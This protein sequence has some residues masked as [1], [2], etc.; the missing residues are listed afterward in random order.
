MPRGKNNVFDGD[1]VPL[2]LLELCYPNIRCIS[3]GEVNVD[4]KF[5]TFTHSVDIDSSFIER[6]GTGTFVFQVRFCIQSGS[7]RNSCLLED[8]L[9]NDDADESDDSTVLE[10]SVKVYVLSDV[11]ERNTITLEGPRS[12]SPLADLPVSGILRG[13]ADVAVANA[14][15]TLAWRRFDFTGDGGTHLC[16]SKEHVIRG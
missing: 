2:A 16:L 10:S 13:P 15:V 3:L 1:A 7:G 4:P 14:T 8:L 11:W 5:G 9:S 6:H 12:V